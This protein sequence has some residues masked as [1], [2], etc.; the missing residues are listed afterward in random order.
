VRNA[1]PIVDSCTTR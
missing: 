1:A